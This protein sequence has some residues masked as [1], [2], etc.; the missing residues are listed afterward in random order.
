MAPTQ[1]TLTERPAPRSGVLATL[2]AATIG[3]IA[4]VLAP[5]VTSVLVDGSGAEEAGT[6]A[7]ATTTTA[8]PTT[9]TTT[10]TTAAPTTTSVPPVTTTASSSNTADPDVVDAF[11]ARLVDEL[12]ITELQARCL[13]RVLDIEQ[14]AGSDDQDIESDVL[15]AALDECGVSL[16]EL[17]DRP[18]D[19]R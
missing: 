16:E 7:G 1:H 12:G 17:T 10:T 3:A 4:T 18:D 15:L 9:T 11:A 5:T 8:A 13:F 14:L 6:V 19:D 2:L